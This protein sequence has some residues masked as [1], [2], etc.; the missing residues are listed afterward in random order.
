MPENAYMRL[1]RQFRRAALIAES[2]SVLNW[3]RAAMMPSGSS[4]VRAEQLAELQALRHETLA[5]PETEDLLRAAESDPGLD[6]WRRANV[7]EMRR[8]WAHATALPVDLVVA[9][10]R[11]CAA[12]EAIWRQARERADFAALLPAFERVLVLV[13]EAA[14]AKSAKLGLAPYDA[15]LDEYEPGARAADIDRL[16]ARLERELPPLVAKALERQATR[17]PPRALGGA[18]PAASQRALAVELMRAFGFDFARGRLDVSAHPFCGGVPGD[19]RLTT[20]YDETDFASGLMSTLHETGHALYE[21]GL[22]AEW[23]GQ[24]VGEARGMSLHESQS[25]LI[26][27]QVCRSREFFDFLAPILRQFLSLAP[28]EAEP[29]NL[30]ALATRVRPGYIR[31]DADEAT[32][33]LHIVFRHQLEQAMLAG[34]LKP[35]DLPAAWTEAMQRHFGLTQPS[36]REG[37]LQ[38]IHWF[39]GAFGY[40]PSY[41]LGAMTAAQL[42]AAAR[43]VLP[44]LAR[45]IAQGRFAPLIGWLGRNVHARA[46][47]ASTEA[48]VAAATGRAL[49]A[50]D[51]LAHLRARYLREN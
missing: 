44:D 49:A 31:V 43:R 42:F 21:M 2:A 10:A 3:D 27:M 40:F 13:R 19:I 20:R 33:P 5:R 51:F 41:T 39:D 14:A 45:D 25:L 6:P 34:D 17:L 9:L 28:A 47:S 15:L 29:A 24:P 32:Y 36:D 50:D 4:A 38:D 26:E 23:R 48:I 22:P 30:H 12:C 46:S 1:E 11:S 8:S 7:A 37:C 18:F 16:F 35:R